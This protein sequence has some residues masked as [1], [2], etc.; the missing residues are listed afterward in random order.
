MRVTFARQGGRSCELPIDSLLDPVISLDAE[1]RVQDLNPAAR[2][3][4]RAIESGNAAGVVLA[5]HTLKGGVGYFGTDRA[6]ELA[7]ELEQK[8]QDNDLQGAPL[9]FQEM[10]A[11]VEDLLT[12]PQEV[13]WDEM[14]A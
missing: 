3:M 5:A 4:L 9:L 6:A 11:E 7:D 2:K 13:A 1:G 10:R 8:G 14:D 12:G